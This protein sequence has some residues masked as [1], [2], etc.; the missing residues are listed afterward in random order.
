LQ[1]RNFKNT[2]PNPDITFY[3]RFSA[4]FHRKSILRGSKYRMQHRSP[5]E[6][7]KVKKVRRAKAND[8]ERV[9]MQTLNQALEKLRTVLPAFPDET[10]LTKIETLRFANNYIW[11]L[12]ETV[13]CTDQ[14]GP[15]PSLGGWEGVW[16]AGAAGGQQR[17]QLQHCALLAQSLMSQQLAAGSPSSSACTSP[18]RGQQQQQHVAHLHLHQQQ[19]QQHH[20]MMTMM[21]MSSPQH[22]DYPIGPHDPYSG[23][24]GP[25][26]MGSPVMPQSP[27]A[28]LPNS[29]ASPLTSGG[30][31]PAE[32]GSPIATAAKQMPDPFLDNNPG[33]FPGAP[34][35]G[36]M[37]H[38]AAPPPLVWEPELAIQPHP[39][40]YDEC[41]AHPPAAS[42]LYGQDLRFNYNNYH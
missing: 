22:A 42:S 8:R 9:R 13:R 35:G 3:C 31:H 36:R 26:M 23:G 14:G 15:P 25:A 11:A 5:T 4:R 17:D 33:Y 34:V 29:P 27:P 6:V 24:V 2:S 19:Q 10:K 32:F 28:L 30:G 40:V 7:S 21:T 38:P 18:V 41:Y 12:K 39:P 1:N 37:T 20:M 16:A